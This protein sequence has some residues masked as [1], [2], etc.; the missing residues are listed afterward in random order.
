MYIGNIKCQIYESIFSKNKRVNLNHKVTFNTFNFYLIILRCSILINLQY[1][2]TRLITNKILQQIF[3]TMS[4][5]LSLTFISFLPFQNPKHPE[6][7]NKNIPFIQ[8]SSSLFFPIDKFLFL[9]ILLSI[10][11]VQFC[12]SKLS[13]FPII[14]RIVVVSR[15]VSGIVT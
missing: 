4:L 2:S 15:T 7:E 13:Q 9:F 12:R 8:I 1:K 14:L 5:N 6:L 3:F 11:I 10:L